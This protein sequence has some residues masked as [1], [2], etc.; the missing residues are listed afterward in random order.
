MREFKNEDSYF[1][2]KSDLSPWQQKT[3]LSIILLGASQLHHCLENFIL[4]DKITKYL[5]AVL[6]DIHFTL[7]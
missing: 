5:M 1:Y 4:P 6:T 2:A 3:T 7:V